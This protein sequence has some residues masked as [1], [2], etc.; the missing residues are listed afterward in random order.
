[1]NASINTHAHLMSFI[2][3]WTHY[4]QCTCKGLYLDQRDTVT[5]MVLPILHHSCGKFL[6]LCI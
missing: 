4:N 1:V 2:M 5:A 6:L 3:K